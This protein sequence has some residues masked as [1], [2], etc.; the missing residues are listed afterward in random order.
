[1]KLLDRPGL[2]DTRLADDERELAFGF[3]R[4]LPAPVEMFELGIVTSS[5]KGLS[6]RVPPP[7]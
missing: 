3:A 1:M 6:L 7:R 5:K 4:L 2:A